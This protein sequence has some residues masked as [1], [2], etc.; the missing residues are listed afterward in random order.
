MPCC[1]GTVVADGSGSARRS[2]RSP[3]IKPRR[4]ARVA[5]QKTSSSTSELMLVNSASGEECRIAILQDGHLEE[6]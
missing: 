5:K 3:V 4:S 2:R 6:L 1:C